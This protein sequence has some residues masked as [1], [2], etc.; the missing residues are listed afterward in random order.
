MRPN[1]STM[2]QA[3]RA[4]EQMNIFNETDE[5]QLLADLGIEFYMEIL[6]PASDDPSIVTSFMALLTFED[7]SQ[8][9]SMF[10]DRTL[11][12]WSVLY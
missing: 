12:I 8:C 10:K 1:S 6:G 11:K 4:V 3:E 2:T 5:K 7:G 9:G